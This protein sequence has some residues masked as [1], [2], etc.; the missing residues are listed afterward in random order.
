LLVLSATPVSE[1]LPMKSN[2]QALPVAG[3]VGDPSN[4]SVK[5]LFASGRRDDTVSF[6]EEITIQIDTDRSLVYAHAWRLAGGTFDDRSSCR[7]VPAST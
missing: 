1:E 7:M 4:G 3:N 6:R 5:S 2:R